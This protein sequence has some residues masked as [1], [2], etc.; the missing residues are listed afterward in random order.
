MNTK[1]ILYN[2]LTSQLEV[3][4]SE[5]EKYHNEVYT[6]SYET[7][8]ESIKEW[9][10]S[11]INAKFEKFEF[12]GDKI[13]LNVDQNSSWRNID[14]VMRGWDPKNISVELDWNGESAKSTEPSTIDKGILIGA[15]AT[16]FHLIENIYKND[17]FPAYQNIV[18]AKK[19]YLKDYENLDKAL[20]NLNNEIWTDSV[21]SMKQIGFTI[22]SFKPDVSLDWEYGNNSERIYK[23]KTHNKAFNLQHGRSM[24]DTTYIN[25]FKVLGKKGNKYSVEVYK[26]GCS[27]ITY[28]N[29]LEK[30]MDTFI[31]NVNNWENRDADVNKLKTEKRYAEYTK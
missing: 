12:T 4:K 18:N 11:K 16:N 6:P 27:T 24:Y 23:I 7:L 22:K 31:F 19:E 2:A 10:T 28:D 9:F 13:T 17:W 21:E 5:T 8:G 29:I 26:D 25:G 1:Q 14:V 15:L 3:K 20:K 30:K